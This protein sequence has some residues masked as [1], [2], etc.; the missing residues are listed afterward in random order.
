MVSVGN[1][2]LMK[3]DE[4][5]SRSTASIGEAAEYENPWAT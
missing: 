3:V 1:L 2:D 4:K 5:I